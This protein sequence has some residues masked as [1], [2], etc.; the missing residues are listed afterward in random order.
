MEVDVVGEKAAQAA[1]DR[2][3][4]VRAGATALVRVLA[5]VTAYPAKHRAGARPSRKTWPRAVINSGST[6][7]TAAHMVLLIFI[8]PPA[9]IF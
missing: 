2:T 1:I 8:A 3:H 7:I 6:R 5:H 9:V 4:D